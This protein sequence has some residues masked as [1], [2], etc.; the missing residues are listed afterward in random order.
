MPPTKVAILGAGFIADIHLES[1]ARFV[2]DAQVTA[3]FSRTAERAQEL[4]KHWGIPQWFTDI[5]ELIAKA[6]CD[7]VDI[8]LPEFSSPPGDCRGGARGQARDRREAAVL[9]RSRRQTT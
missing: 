2:P 5:D 6:D 9:S 3:V 8:C 4:A 1:F 7:V